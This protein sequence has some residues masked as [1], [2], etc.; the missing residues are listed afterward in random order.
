MTG[1]PL[2]EAAA[3]EVSHW[4][5][6]EGEGGADEEERR[7]RKRRTRR[8]RGKRGRGRRGRGGNKRRSKSRNRNRTGGGRGGSGSRSDSWWRGRWRHPRTGGLLRN[9]RHLL[10]SAQHLCK[11]H[12]RLRAY[13]FNGWSMEMSEATEDSQSV[14]LKGLTGNLSST[15]YLDVAD[16]ELTA[17]LGPPLRLASGGRSST[18]R[19][20][21]CGCPTSATGH[22]GRRT[23]QKTVVASQAKKHQCIIRKL[24]QQLTCDCNSTKLIQ[25]EHC[26]KHTQPQM[27][28]RS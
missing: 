15:G 14:A 2:A 25:G 3:G 23:T 16:E 10:Y 22:A 6:V 24:M 26:F 7:R 9:S 28:P 1:F 20:L 27:L 12:C 4:A 21:P 8:G 18:N 11:T 13:P 17:L 19:L 5:H